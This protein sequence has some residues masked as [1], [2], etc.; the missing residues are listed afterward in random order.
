MKATEL[1]LVLL[2]V[3]AG[4]LILQNAHHGGNGIHLRKGPYGAE[5][6]YASESGRGCCG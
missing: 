2:V 1:L 5:I 3:G 6:D 4:V